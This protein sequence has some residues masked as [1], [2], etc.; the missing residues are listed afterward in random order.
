MALKEAC[1]SAPVLGYPDYSIPFILHTDSS[2]DG[3][4]AVLY[5]QQ[6]ESKDDIR[7]IA[8]ASRS[9][10]ASEINYAPH[11]L[12]F[13]ALKWAVTD[14]FKEYLYGEN[15]FE[16]YTDNTPLTYIL[17]TAKLDACGQ[18]WVADLANFNFTLHYKPGS[19]NT[20]ADAL[21]RIVWPDILTQADTEEFESMPA[22]MVQA[23]CLG[24]LCE[25]LIDNAAYGLSVLPLEDHI[26]GQRGWNKDDWVQLQYN[27]PDLKILIDCFNN[28][29]IKKRPFQPSDS[30]TLKHYFRIQNQ[31][32]LIDGVLYRTLSNNSQHQHLQ[33]QI[34]LP[35]EL[36]HRVMQGC[37]DETGHQGRDRTISLV[38]ER[39]YWD[40]LYKDTSEYVAQ[41]QRCLRRKGTSRPALLQP[42]F[43]TQPLEIIH[44]DH[45][46]LEP[47]KGQYESVLVV[48]DHFTRYAQAYAVKNLTALTT[49]KV[50][51]EQFLR[52]YG[53]PQKILTDQGPGFES[54]LFQ[55]LMSMARIEKLRTTSY[56]PQTNGHCE[57]FNSTLM[58]MLGTLTP[59]QKKDW[60]SHLLT[61]CHAYNSTQHS[62]TGF[63][64]YYLMFGRHPRLPIDYQLGITRDNLAQPSKFRFV[65]K[66]NERLHEAYA[67]A[68]ALTQEEANRQKKLYDRRS[69]DVVLTPGDLVLVRVV[70]WTER[71][72]IQ[73]KWEQE[74]YVVVSQPDPFLPVYKVRPISGGNTRTLHRNLL[75]PLG[76]QMKS[77]ED[78]DSSDIAFDEVREKS[79]TPPEVGIFPD[80]SSVHPPSENIDSNSEEVAGIVD[81]IASTNGENLQQ[82]ENNVDSTNQ[83]SNTSTI[84][85]DDNLS[86]LNEFWELV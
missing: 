53:F 28:N 1:T 69:K 74:E 63:S 8:Y 4:G 48:T 60:K 76:L 71:H 34:V 70:K 27:D 30:K 11:K 6:G 29:T 51:W 75:L 10:T 73:D 13:L 9:L 40:T 7:V 37:H 18:R 79:L 39:F 15:K 3:L 52:H 85:M 50:L 54:Q 86:G 64:P 46:T 81:D 59:D 83:D 49:A 32:K 21:S 36:F 65:N 23:L 16:V 25:S 17:T 66:L 78:Q 57:R 41:C 31:L 84:D 24:V 55:K 2:T 22:N 58:N 77:T 45:L 38:R 72:K 68:E 14:K 19:T 82:T 33:H 47:C 5:Q 56:H 80:G 42:F 35:K 44:L 61:M 26:P 43:A 67:K 12:E 20:V 62:V